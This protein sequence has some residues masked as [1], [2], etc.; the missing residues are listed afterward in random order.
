MN[1][2]INIAP[3]PS[4]IACG[5]TCLHALYRY[6]GEDTKLDEL[7][8]EIPQLNN[9][10][11]LGVHL[12]AHALR[13]GFEATISTYNLQLFDPTWFEPE[14][15]MKERLI[16]Q[17]EAK[18]DRRLREATDAYLGFLELGGRIELHELNP[19][20]LQS[21]IHRGP[22]LVGLSATYLYRNCRELPDRHVSDDI[23]GMPVGHFVL[24][25]RCDPITNRVSVADPWAGNPMATGQHYTVSYDR[26]A[27]AILLSIVTYDA[28]L[29][30][31]S[32]SDRQ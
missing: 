15:N 29:L 9:G 8:D 3:Q 16:L 6:Y 10:G 7:M 21:L 32:L 1:I 26:L 4:D 17:A 2:R 12:A 19:R 14:A 20:R 23:R 24:L 22:L 5:A 30:S 27:A 11:T 18:T 13:H 28:N 31:I 25:E